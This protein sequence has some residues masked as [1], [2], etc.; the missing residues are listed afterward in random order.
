VHINGLM[1]KSLSIKSFIGRKTL[2]DT[3]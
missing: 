2:T 3:D 1:L